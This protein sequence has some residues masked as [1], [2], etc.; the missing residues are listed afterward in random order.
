MAQIHSFPPIAAPGACVLVLGS[1]PGVA[2][3]RLRQYYGHPRNAFW[4]IMGALLDFDA[5]RDYAGRCAALVQHGI[6][7]WDVLAACERE[8]SLDAAIDTASVVPN[9]IAGFLATH[10]SIARICFNGASAERLFARHVAPQMALD[11]T[12]Q[13]L[14]LPST[15]P[16][17]A[18]MPYAHK[19]LAWRAADIGAGAAGRARRC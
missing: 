7:L 16:A 11:G 3:L 13:C 14:R 8:G 17:H 10:R 18:G 1:M 2:S 4:N 15:S 19:L 12:V 9:D 5:T 6:A